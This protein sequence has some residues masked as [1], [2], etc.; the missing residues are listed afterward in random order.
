MEKN[1][2]VL[3]ISGSIRKESYTRS[4]TEYIARTFENKGISAYHWNL[5][6]KPLPIMIPELRD[7][8]ANHPDEN[9]RTFADLALSC[10]A[11]VL[12]SPIYHNSFSGVLKNA[13][14]HLRNPHFAYK[15]MGLVSH[16]GD[17]S[18][19]AV[20][21]L[22]IVGRGVNAIVTPTIICTSEDDFEGFE[23]TS[24]SI[25]KRVDRFCDE[26]ML[27]TE[28]FRSIRAEQQKMIKDK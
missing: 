5:L 9:V 20:D 8:S 3:L 28:T 19:Q 22:R 17:G 15:P 1:H 21:Q 27:F 24:D 2:T 14:D 25:K 4:L 13:L 16:G 6:E 7:D 11:T 12:S 26:L 18:K 23:L 10:D